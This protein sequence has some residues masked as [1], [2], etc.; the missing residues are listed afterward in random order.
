MASRSARTWASRRA[1]RPLT[2]S[3]RAISA[4]V[5]IAQVE[6]WWTS[7]QDPVLN[8]LILN[9]YSQNLSLQEAGCRVL[10]A[11]AQLAVT[12][13]DLFPQKQTAGAQY[14]RAAASLVTNGSPGLANQFY[15]DTAMGFNLSWE[16]DFW[17]RFRRAVTAQEHVLQASCFN[18]NH[19]LVT[20]LGDVASNYVQVRT[21]QQ[22]MA[23]VQA[24]VDLQ[25]RILTVAERRL[26]AGSRN[27]VDCHQARS[28][29]AQ[30][31]AQIPQLKLAMRQA[32]DRLCVLLGRPAYD[33]ERELGFCPIPT[34]P[35]V[36]AIGLPCDLLRRRPD[37]QRAERLAYA[38]AEQIGIAEAALY[39]AFFING[40]IGVESEQLNQL[41]TNPALT[42][43]IGPSFQWNILNY[44]RIRNNMR[45]QEARFQAL[46]LAYQETV[47]K[48]NAEVED[49]LAAYLL[50]Q[51]RTGLLDR[52]VAESRQAADLITRE[53]QGGTADFNHVAL[54]EQNLVQQQDMQVQSHGDIAEGLIQLYR[55]L[56]GGWQ[57]PPRAHVATRA[58][59]QA[60]PQAI[61]ASSD[62][63]PGAAQGSGNHAAPTSERSG[64][65]ARGAE[66][67]RAPAFV[68]NS[69][70]GADV[71]H[72]AAEFV[73]NRSP[74]AD[75]AFRPELVGSKS[76]PAPMPPARQS[77][78]T[79]VPLAPMPPARQVCR[80]QICPWRRCRRN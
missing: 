54:I 27:A 29:L 79:T 43:A 13:G 40:T 71:P 50:A 57:I 72:L 56:G 80:Q 22:R 6:Q 21:L 32:C 11:R 75:A 48:A 42:G 23:Y 8:Q 73:G 5:T 1:P 28:T 58:M 62:H 60:A 4:C 12:R 24:N 51:D 14:Q 66:A 63:P 15:N 16:I 38:Q 59:P 34:A 30:T 44:G 74:G 65:H 19:V 49:C 26:K 33:L 77:L 41:F 69:S 53:Y 76:A 78:S 68:G 37:V 46:V 18:Y 35:A 20:L 70:G 36:I 45:V 61:P 31:E 7:F 17:G 55:A 2:G 10:E 39:P 67:A 3:T 52:S 25:N 47:L 9:A 64:G